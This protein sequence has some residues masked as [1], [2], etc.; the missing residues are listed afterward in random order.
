MT[1]LDDTRAALPTEF[2]KAIDIW[3]G[4][5]KWAYVSV[6][7]SLDFLSERGEA[8]KTKSEISRGFVNLYRRARIEKR[9]AA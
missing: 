4:M 7:H 8:E 9:E 1:V 5:N 6:S 3:R 2:T